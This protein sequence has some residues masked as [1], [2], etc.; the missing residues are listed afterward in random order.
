M[1]QSSIEWRNSKLADWKKIPV[2]PNKTHA[3]LRRG[4]QNVARAETDKTDDR[5][6]KRSDPTDYPRE[7]PK[8]P[9][10]RSVGSP[11]LATGK[12]NHRRGMRSIGFFGKH[13][14]NFRLWVTSVETT[15]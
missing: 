13:E 8:N 6:K 1:T 5:V 12:K 7:K 9:K 14:K 4:Q 2:T 3:E 10:G 15:T 11:C